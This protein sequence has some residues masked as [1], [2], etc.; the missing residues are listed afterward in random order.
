MV[1]PAPSRWRRF[2]PSGVA[3]QLALLVILAIIAIHALLTASFRLADRTVASPGETTGR[4]AAVVEI[5]DRAPVDQRPGLLAAAAA[6]LPQLRLGLA[7]ASATLHEDARGGPDAR[8]LGRA[9]GPAFTV[10]TLLPDEPQPSAV[11]TLAVRLR[12]LSFVVA[13]LPRP[14]PPPAGP[15]TATI[16]FLIICAVLLG[17][18][19]GLALTRPLRRIA[20]AV[21]SYGPGR[22]TSPLAEDGPREVRIVARAFNRMQERIA[23]LLDDRTRALAAVSHDLRTPITRLRLRAEAI[24]DAGERARTIA[25]LD[26]MAALVQ[27]A[28]AHLR[29]G[30]SDEALTVVDLAS[31]VQTV[32]DQQADLGRDIPVTV[33]E[34]LAVRGRL[35]E[36]ERAVANLADNAGRYGRAPRIAVRRDDDA[37]LVEI[38]DQGPG[39]PRERRSELLEPFVRGDAART[40][41]DHDGFGLGLTIARTVAEAHGGA[42]ELADGVDGAFVARLRLP[43]A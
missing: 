4:L 16:A 38:I 35:L 34:R 42:L 37:A 26:Q 30:Q 9:L 15:L 5:L 40:M 17:G 18:W 33:A 23:R 36:L 43:L 8:H 31:L 32:A 20:A 25:D 39:I 27:S 6:G 11:T 41:N 7:S 24:P 1:P 3:A 14:P 22:E 29:D 2:W 13:T 10:S 28:L 19:A 12:D 21:E